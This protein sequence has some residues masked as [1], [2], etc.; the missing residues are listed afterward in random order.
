MAG[1]YARVCVAALV[2]ILNL[3]DA[4][5]IQGSDVMFACGLP[6]TCFGASIMNCSYGKLSTIPTY[7]QPH[8]TT[9]DVSH[10]HINHFSWPELKE[11][12]RITHLNLSYNN[13]FDVTLSTLSM[14][15]FL[16]V[17]DIGNNNLQHFSM[18][19][20]KFKQQSKY[21]SQKESIDYLLP[22]LK[23]LLLEK[24]NLSTVPKGL[25]NLQRLQTLQL[26]NNN[27]STIGP[28]DFWGCS[29]V[30][31]LY[32]QN[33]K[34]NTIHIRAFIDLKE[35][36]V[37][38]LSTNALITIHPVLFIA[39]NKPQFQID[40]SGN[41][42]ICDC[43]LLPF[44]KFLSDPRNKIWHI[45]C[46]E[47]SNLSGQPLGYV[48]EFWLTCDVSGQD[49]I[50]LYEVTILEGESA[51][52]HCTA[53]EIQDIT[54]TYWQTP[55]GIISCSHT[56]PDMNIDKRHSLTITS[57]QKSIEGLYLCTSNEIVTGQIII[58]DVHIQ[59]ENTDASARHTRDVK[60]VAR[61]G[62]TQNEFTMAIC[63]SIIIT[64]I[65]A[66]CLGAFVRPFIEP[67]WSKIR[68]RK[69]SVNEYEN[70]GFSEESTTREEKKEEQQH[71]KTRA[72]L[73]HS[74][75]DVF[76]NAPSEHACSSAKETSVLR[77][78][79]K[80]C[81][82][83]NTNGI[84]QEIHFSKTQ[85]DNSNLFYSEQMQ[86][87]DR[88]A[89][90]V[91]KHG[92]EN[93]WSADMSTTDSVPSTLKVVPQ[94]N[95]DS[96]NQKTLH[97][98]SHG[99]E[100][101]TGKQPH[102]TKY[103][104][105]LDDSS[106]AKMFTGH[107]AGSWSSDVSQLYGQDLQ[108][109][110]ICALN[111]DETTIQGMIDER[112]NFQELKNDI[113]ISKENTSETGSL[114]SK[115]Q[116][117]PTEF[118]N[119]ITTDVSTQLPRVNEEASS[120]YADGPGISDL[121]L[122]ASASKGLLTSSQGLGETVHEDAINSSS[123]K[124]NLITSEPENENQRIVLANINIED[125]KDRNYYM[126]QTDQKSVGTQAS[127]DSAYNDL[128]HNEEYGATNGVT[129]SKNDIFPESN[130]YEE[131]NFMQ[132]QESFLMTNT[133]S[134][135]HSSDHKAS[136]RVNIQSD[137]SYTTETRE[138]LH[139]EGKDLYASSSKDVDIQLS[140]DDK[141][142]LKAQHNE[143]AWES[144]V[145]HNKLS[146]T[147]LQYQDNMS[148][149]SAPAQWET[150]ASEE[151]SAQQAN[152]STGNMSDIQILA[153]DDFKWNQ[154]F[155]HFSEMKSDQ[156]DFFLSDQDS[157]DIVKEQKKHDWDQWQFLD[158]EKQADRG[159][160]STNSANN[161][162][163][164]GFQH[165]STGEA[166][167]SDSD[168][169]NPFQNDDW[170]TFEDPFVTSK[171]YPSDLDSFIPEKQLEI[172]APLVHPGNS[173]IAC[174]Q[175]PEDTV[176][177]TQAGQEKDSTEMS[178]SF[179]PER[180]LI[181]KSDPEILGPS[182]R[183]LSDKSSTYLTN[184]FFKAAGSESDVTDLHIEVPTDQHK[185]PQSVEEHH[186]SD[187]EEIKRLYYS[188]EISL[189]HP[190][191]LQFDQETSIYEHK[192][193]AFKS[194]IVSQSE[195]E[196][197]PD[198]QDLE[199][200]MPQSDMNF[201]LTIPPAFPGDHSIPDM[202]VNR[203]LE[204]YSLTGDDFETKFSDDDTFSHGSW[205]AIDEPFQSR[206]ADVLPGD[207][208]TS[209]D[210]ESREGSSGPKTEAT[211][212]KE[213][214]SKANSSL[215]IMQSGDINTIQGNVH[216]STKHVANQDEDKSGEILS[217]EINWSP[218]GTVNLFQEDAFSE[219]SSTE[220]TTTQDLYASDIKESAVSEGIPAAGFSMDFNILKESHIS[221]LNETKS[222]KHIPH[223]T[224][225]ADE[226]TSTSYTSTKSLQE[227]KSK[228]KMSLLTGSYFIKKKKAFDGFSSTFHSGTNVTSTNI[229]TSLSASLVK[230]MI[231]PSNAVEFEQQSNQS[232]LN[233]SVSAHT[234]KDHMNLLSESHSLKVSI[235]DR[236]ELSI[237][238][239]IEGTSY[240]DISS[241]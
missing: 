35:L 57:A 50:S 132:M 136:D 45:E 200:I 51:I 3:T 226:I 33:N 38:N 207:H 78:E 235:N 184:A 72:A 64:F 34:I 209:N 28:D 44:K 106:D 62:R 193:N 14:L 164:F 176:R 146:D 17:L 61:E 73:V 18:D 93:S 105:L 196:N 158:Q 121:W 222:P 143:N 172:R 77:T 187:L 142:L 114:N 1:P 221:S 215:L 174:Q 70:H 107:T 22:Y 48:E 145:K 225:E 110:H 144:Q 210:V 97:V 233:Q 52:L 218:S 213:I 36:K 10:N 2:F 202:S 54:S 212:L 182:D 95:E 66:F 39:I 104:G 153:S 25:G 55:Q 224:L 46:T 91:V 133:E 178:D 12:W 49:F 150:F 167:G 169:F 223:L 83:S 26:S 99:T 186:L 170:F 155:N 122:D 111:N 31:E 140:P 63:L 183:E 165:C 135:E 43:R 7:V 9:L 89:V 88:P 76:V 134:S 137:S 37:L 75:E 100:S 151:L 56:H 47:P 197:F 236:S 211:V 8:L 115:F 199:T 11:I 42:W 116:H 198:T 160:Q 171:D 58:Y 16:E 234:V 112:A 6:C 131:M 108:K 204:S 185:N 71:S 195:K 208:L 90:L 59:T 87:Y 67:L 129:I 179:S 29:N 15:Y 123:L 21:P 237:S 201:F 19:K 177:C 154:D 148:S 103:P 231:Q 192:L 157:G 161:V 141:Y 84:N 240:E 191:N 32:L 175:L 68:R 173:Q 162:D 74:T 65:C 127:V 190:S 80:K 216:F 130:V 41:G 40:L 227:G 166:L 113:P 214:P 168:N 119:C 81:Q 232:F 126:S 125:I 86:T 203:Y 109:E 163:L 27:I 101:Q 149:K 92:I 120:A 159:S 147:E 139:S 20:F 138:Y 79:Y 82:N 239:A 206:C 124:V 117:T 180:K 118:Q 102:M 194:N 230:Q 181:S 220:I 24:N 228:S 241:A 189:Q 219:R 229:P 4:K 60:S 69:S 188:S 5:T 23:E 94:V 152:A 85:N 217:E 13:I 128:R 238:T 30:H 53:D 96:I 205:V 156:N 98:S